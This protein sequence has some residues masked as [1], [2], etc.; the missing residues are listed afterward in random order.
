[1][2]A[3][4]GSNEVVIRNFFHNE[5]KNG[6]PLIFVECFVKKFSSIEVVPAAMVEIR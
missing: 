3:Y 2:K 5:T 6:S 1:M 4:L